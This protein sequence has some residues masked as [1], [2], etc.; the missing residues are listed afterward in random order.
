MEIIIDKNDNKKEFIDECYGILYRYKKILNKPKTKIKARSKE[1]IGYLIFIII[2]LLF[3]LIMSIL[4]Q[5]PI[6]YICLGVAIVSF[7]L[8]LTKL[9]RYKELIRKYLEQ[10]TNSV[11]KIEKEKIIL[12]NK[13][14]ERISTININEIKQILITKNCIAF[15]PYF[16]KTKVKNVIFIPSCYK[17][18]IQNKIK[19][20]DIINN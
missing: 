13:E 16:D 17:E 3:T 12:D 14:I 8:T 19:N 9:L 11:L 18:E 7:M 15:M 10:K 2:Y 4:E 20:I 6:F 1:L 5:N